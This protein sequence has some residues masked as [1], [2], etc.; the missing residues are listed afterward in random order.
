M[1]SKAR[2]LEAIR[3]RLEAARAELDALADLPLSAADARER[4]AEWVDAQA[5]QFA[6][7]RTAAMFQSPRMDSLPLRISAY[8]ENDVLSRVD[9]AP[10]LCWLAGD[11]IKAKLA[12]ALPEVADVPAL[13]DRPGIAERLREEIRALEIAEEIA[14]RRAEAAGESVTRRA[15]ADPAL[16][17]APGAQLAEAA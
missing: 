14:V 1:T 17:L 15:E 7:E 6:P 2:S 4:I 12:D 3:K 16:V 8:R 9:T 11:A 5:A 13:A 10:L